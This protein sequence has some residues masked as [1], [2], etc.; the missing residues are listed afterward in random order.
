M[1]PIVLPQRIQAAKK[2]EHVPG[3]QIRHRRGGRERGLGHRVIYTWGGDGAADVCGGFV[4][5]LKKKS[6]E[7]RKRG[8]HATCVRMVSS[9][10]I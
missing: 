6:R 10:N 1:L 3:Q 2:P 5:P 4:P 7:R 9:T 8:S